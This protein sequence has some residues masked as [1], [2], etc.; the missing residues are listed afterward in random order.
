MELT[1]QEAF[2]IIGQQTVTIAKLNALIAQ[3]QMQLQE[4]KKPKDKQEE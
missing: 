1:Q 4:A 2:T 3:L